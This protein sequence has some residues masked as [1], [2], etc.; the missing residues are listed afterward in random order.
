V[1]RRVLYDILLPIA[2]IFLIVATGYYLLMKFAPGADKV[3]N[4][5][6]I[7]VKLLIVILTALVGI[8]IAV[9][10]SIQR[11]TRESVEEDLRK[12][13]SEIRGKLAISDGFT[14]YNLELYD[15]AIIRTKK[16]LGEN[17]TELDEIL[18]KNNLAYYY[19]AKH[20]QYALSE[21]EK[22]EAETWAKF[23]YSKYDRWN[24][25]YDRPTWVETYTFVMSRLAKGRQESEKIIQEIRD[26]LGR[27]EFDEIKDDLI[28]NLKYLESR[29]REGMA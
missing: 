18:A 12:Q 16:A 14:A 15:M 3:A 26:I 19:A 23:I 28:A 22:K 13:F 8:G 24:K 27:P 2:I 10:W 25:D 1:V 20:E 29:L 11:L 5:F 6:P 9:F 4:E 7:F 21:V 17:L